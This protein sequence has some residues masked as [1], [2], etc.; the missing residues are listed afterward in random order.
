V[1]AISL[2]FH[3]DPAETLDLLGAWLVGLDV[4]VVD[5]RLG[6]DPVTRHVPNLDALHSGWTDSVT[7]LL[8]V[9]PVEHGESLPPFGSPVLDRDWRRNLD[10][11]TIVV[12]AMTSE[13][14]RESALG[15]VSND[16]DRVRTWRRIKARAQRTMHHGGIAVNPMTARALRSRAT[17]TPTTRAGCMN[18][19]HA[20]SPLLAGCTTNWVQARDHREA[21]SLDAF[22]AW[23]V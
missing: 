7:H 2:Q 15:A 8:G 20:C 3:A 10:C 14:L 19:V 9:V 6:E 16:T 4:S 12:G 17:G 11:L 23:W 18:A 5:E 1:P 22:Q 13:G 21:G